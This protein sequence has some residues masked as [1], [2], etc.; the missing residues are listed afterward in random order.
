MR[1]ASKE[2]IIIIKP[3]DNK[4]GN[5]SFSGLKKILLDPPDLQVNKMTE[6]VHLFLQYKLGVKNNTLTHT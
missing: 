4:R 2:S 6:F 5:E 1:R 3:R